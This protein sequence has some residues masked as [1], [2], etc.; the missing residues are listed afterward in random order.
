MDTNETVTVRTELKTDAARVWNLYA[1]HTYG[2][3]DLPL[4]ACREALQ[5]SV[6]ACRK[7]IADGTVERG[8]F[9]VCYDAAAGVLSFEDNGCGMDH[10]QL[11]TVFLTLGGSG[12]AGDAGATGGFGVAK[13]VI[14]GCS[15][16]AT[17]A[18][19][20]RDNYVPSEHLG[21]TVAL[22]EQ[23]RPWRRGTRITVSGF[24]G[25]LDAYCGRH[26][27][28]VGLV[29]RLRDLLGGCSLPEMDL[30]VNGEEVEPLFPA[31]RATTLELP[32]SWGE[33]VAAVAAAAFGRAP[34][35]GRAHYFIRV[36]GLVQHHRQLGWSCAFDRDVVIEL[37]PAGKPDDENYPL[38]TSRDEVRG[39]ARAGLSALVRELEEA[40]KPPP[41]GPEYET[42]D[43]D[44]QN[45]YEFA[46]QLDAFLADLEK[47][48]ALAATL[49]ASAEPRAKRRSEIVAT[50][51]AATL[52]EAIEVS[53]AALPE[54]IADCVA[55]GEELTE[56]QKGTVIQIVR[57]RAEGAWEADG[58]GLGAVI[59]ARLVEAQLDPS[60]GRKRRDPL[61]GAAL[62]KVSRKNYDPAKAKAFR[63]RPKA[64][65]PLLLAWDACCRIIARAADQSTS[66][67]PGF[68]LDDTLRAA[69]SEENG[70]RF[71]LVNPDW[72]QR[73]V[74][75]NR[76]K[77]GGWNLVAACVH[78]VAC[79]ELAHLPRMDA[80]HDERF[81]VL[82]ETIGLQSVQVL[83]AMERVCSAALRAVPRAAGAGDYLEALLAAV[84][85]HAAERASENGWE[86]VVD[87][88][89]DRLRE[90][91][92]RRWTPA[93]AIKAVAESAGAA[94]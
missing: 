92:G 48:G 11:H 10:A 17:W 34:E 30:R 40:A 28:N 31:Y 25:E 56:G 42:F 35:S 23:K 47:R 33:G 85:S 9:E 80:D 22:S 38:T 50:G 27:R 20:S 19:H 29:V 32:A 49:T 36:N 79:H 43:P 66:F 62:V 69:A 94:A 63:A 87:W 54:W 60:A 51:E 5:N 13:A 67:R 93:S 73:V 45:A 82:R 55:A 72:L 52:V 64:S 4:V 2:N 16:T 1:H 46:G 76:H 70:K 61:G 3:G 78:I 90:V 24:R 15:P 6:D 37:T 83:P 89:D 7:S 57:R 12:K 77:A 41:E 71:L 81:A 18:I 84:R 74:D 68:V 8:F 21:Q 91:I 53:G 65:L 26:G 44:D 58:G 59:G 75:E 14:L 86:R 88:S 39:P